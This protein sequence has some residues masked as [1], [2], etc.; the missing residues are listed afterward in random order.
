MAGPVFSEMLIAPGTLLYKGL[1]VP[2]DRLLKDTRTFYLTDDPKYAD[3]YG[4]H[5]CTYRVKKQ[6][7]LFEMTH[8]NIQ[9]VLEMPRLKPMTKKR[10]RMAFGTGVT[11]GDQVAFLKEQKKDKNI[12]KDVNLTARGQ[13]ASW[14]NLNRLMGIFFSEEFLIPMGYDGYYAESKRT[15]FHAGQFRSEIMLFNAYQRIER[16]PDRLPVVS[17]RSLAFP[18]VVS[19]LFLEY[20]RRTKYLIR[21]TRPFTVFCTGGQAVNLYL[22]QR[23]SAAKHVPLIRRTTDYDFSF[24]LAR[25]PR[26]MTDLRAKGEAMRRFMLRH[27]VGF[28][29]YINTN[30][31]GAN[32][33]LRMKQGRR[34]L[35]PGLQVPAT[36]RR[37]YLV[38]TWQL[39]IGKELIDVADTA[40]SLYPGITRASLSQRFSRD[41]GI[42]I[43]Q[44]KY[45]TI[46]ALGILSGSFLYKTQVAARNPLTGKNKNKGAKNVARAN[47]LTRVITRHSENYPPALV[48]L[49]NKTQ[50]LLNKIS[51]K[52]VRGARI[53]AATVNALVKNLVM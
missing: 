8:E 5:I 18:N 29:K 34:T 21:P 50:N 32:V 12:P 2:C 19:R 42:P 26:N 48:R 44:V 43:Q 9:K 36:Q 17:M 11:V 22:R 15:V 31:K 35:N 38:F 25:P 41:T 13:R 52:N 6:L 3:Q 24:A 10:L 37:T 33:K 4:K 45:Q 40:L 39:K 16:H 7:R 27:M 46:N 49:A 53:E 1:P 14:T 30:Y 51:K 20:S 23:T 28:V 47:Q